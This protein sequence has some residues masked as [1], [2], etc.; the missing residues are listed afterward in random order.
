MATHRLTPATPPVLLALGEPAHTLLGLFSDGN[1]EVYQNFVKSQPEFFASTGLDE[2][3]VSR[4][5]RLIAL[6]TKCASKSSLPF[7]EI[8]DTLKVDVNDIELWI[9]DGA[10]LT[11]RARTG[12][13][14]HALLGVLCT[15]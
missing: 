1:L 13:H 8:A 4:K 12:F 2:S 6:A 9:I 11:V 7:S 10:Y 3:A 5:V 15:H 14:I